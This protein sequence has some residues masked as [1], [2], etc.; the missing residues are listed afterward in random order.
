MV[1]STDAA[2][3]IYGWFIDRMSAGMVYRRLS[4]WKAGQPVK[5]TP[6][7]GGSV[8]GSMRDLVKTLKAS[9]TQRQY[10]N[11]RIP[12]LTRL[13]DVTVTGC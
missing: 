5:V 4:D 7:S 2:R 11:L 1:F 13:R 8:S 9:R 12:S 6:V 10:N 3:E